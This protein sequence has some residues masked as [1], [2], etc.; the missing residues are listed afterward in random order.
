GDQ[1]DEGRSKKLGDRSPYV[2]SA[3]DAQS[4]SLILFGEPGRIPGDA[5]GETV[6]SEAQEKGTD[7][8]LVIGL[9]ES[10]HEGRDGRDYQ[11]NRHQNPATHAVCKYAQGQ[12]PKCAVKDGDG[13]EP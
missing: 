6:A 4:E 9:R 13:G 12:A 10:D 5:D 3:K 7:E 8:Q 11:E 1:S 2:A